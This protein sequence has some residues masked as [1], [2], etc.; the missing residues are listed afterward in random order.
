M[1]ANQINERVKKAKQILK[2]FVNQYKIRDLKNRQNQGINR[3]QASIGP[4][5]R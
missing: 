2:T 1:N 3:Q 4:K 5:N